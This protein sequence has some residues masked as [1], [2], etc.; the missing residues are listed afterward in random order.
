MVKA[1]LRLH[2]Q[3]GARRTE[4]ISICDGVIRL[5]LTAPPVE[6]RA[7][8]ALIDLLSKRLGVPKSACELAQGK[9]GR[10]KLVTVEGIET[11]EALSRLGQ[12]FDR[13][14]KSA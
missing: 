7:N 14:T 4:L 6:G 3:P 9:S 5:K 1:T 8:I 10:D 2:V 13:P 12:S 11:D